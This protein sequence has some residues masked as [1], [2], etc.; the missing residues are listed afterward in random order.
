MNMT[1]S[2]QISLMFEIKHFDKLKKYL[3]KVN[4]SKNKIFKFLK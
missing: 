1:L 3:N 4:N 2:V